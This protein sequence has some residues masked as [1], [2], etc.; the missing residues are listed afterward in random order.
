MNDSIKYIE[1]FYLT[2]EQLGIQSGVLKERILDMIAS[3]SLPNASYQITR[4]VQITSLFGSSSKSQTIHY[5][6]K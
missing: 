1:D 3:K 4:T 5:Y 6:N 2:L